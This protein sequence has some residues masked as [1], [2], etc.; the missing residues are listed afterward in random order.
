MVN[1]T[2]KSAGSILRVALKAPLHEL[3]DYLPPANAMPQPGQRVRVPFG[4]SERVGV[5]AAIADHSAVPADKLK[6]VTAL[7]DAAPLLDEQLVGLLNWASDYYQHPPGDVYAAALPALLR[8]GGPAAS[9]TESRWQ[10]SLAGTEA[11]ANNTGLARAKVQ[12]QVLQLLGQAKRPLSAEELAD[13]HSGWR[14]AVQE[15]VA[16]SYVDKLEVELDGLPVGGDELPPQLNPD[17]LRAIESIPAS[18]F[19]PWLLEGVTGSGKTEVYLALIE[20]QLAAGRQALVLVPEI[21]LTPQLIARFCSRLPVTV[22]TLHSNLSDSERLNNWIAARSGKARVVIGTRSAI[23]TPFAELGL[24]IID[25]EHDSSFKQQE[26][27]RYSARDVALWR[28]RQLDIPVVLGSATPSF[29]SLANVNAGRYR[30]V[31]LPE[32]AGGAQHPEVRIVDLRDHAPS[33]GLTQPLS[34]AIRRHLDADGQVLVYLNRRG[35]APTLFCDGCGSCVECRRCDA[36]MVVHQKQQRIV[37]HHCGSERPPPPKCESCGGELHPLGLGTER[38]EQALTEQFADAALVRLDRDTTRRKGSL[39]EKLDDIRSGKA[40]ILLGTQ[41]LTKGHD[42][43]NVTLVAIIDADQGLFGTDFRAG[44][45]MAQSFVQ[46]SGRAGRA[47][48]KGEVWLQTAYPDHP[49]LRSLLE[50]GYS[51]YAEEALAERESTG[52]PPYTKV[53]LLRAEAADRDKL[54][55]FLD[56]ARGLADSLNNGTPAAT[57][58]GPAS[59]PM[60]R[61]SGRWRGQLLL[62]SAARPALQALLTRWR[63]A[64]AAHPLSNT[65]RW[66]VDVDPSELF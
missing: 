24:I 11:L 39:V 60:E 61:R 47:D 46:V 66:S 13:C 54:Y 35:F 4:R 62:Q 22:T 6:P 2:G 19:E 42:F 20:Q 7:V 25:E 37:C 1:S 27:F 16:K 41:M 59:A 52:W 28:A 40:R 55:R 31:G 12:L 33:D 44:E 45:R 26:G 56:A 57:V 34:G 18:G 51:G 48:R 29:E 50:K 43:P 64:L 36:R 3:F 63:H 15:L 10:I 32:R 23:F 21:G 8:K 30:R 58:L 14:R 49:L 65:V 53:A 17:Q 5:V 9:T 38:I